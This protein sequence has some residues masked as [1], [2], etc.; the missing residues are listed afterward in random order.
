MRLE[1]LQRPLGWGSAVIGAG[2]LASAGALGHA[3]GLDERRGAIRL[4]GA[5]DVVIGTGILGARDRRRWLWARTVA[6]ALDTVLLA[7]SL[8]GRR[9]GRAARLALTAGAVGLTALDAVVASRARAPQRSPWTAPTATEGVPHES[10]RGSALAE[11]I[12][13]PQDVEEAGELDQDEREQRMR[14]AQEQLG[15]PDPDTGARI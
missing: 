12:R 13:S 2:C 11:E 6:D 3:L 1:Q 5:R 7:G 15:L 8:A 14:D 4:M 9:R 10:W